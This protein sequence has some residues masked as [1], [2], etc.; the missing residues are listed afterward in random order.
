MRRYLPHS[1]LFSLALLLSPAYGEAVFRAE[2]DEALK[3]FWRGQ[4]LLASDHLHPLGPTPLKEAEGSRSD[5]ARG[6]QVLNQWKAG[7]PKK[8]ITWRREVA[9]NSKEVIGGMMYRIPAWFPLPQNANCLYQFKIPMEAIRGMQFS[10]GGMNNVLTRIKGEIGDK[11]PEGQVGGIGALRYLALQAP[12]KAGSPARNLFFDFNPSGPATFS[13]GGPTI[14]STGAWVERHGD[15]LLVSYGALGYQ[16]EPYF[17]TWMVQWRISEDAPDAY[18]RLHAEQ[19][20]AYFGH[21][22]TIFQWSFGQ[23]TL[24]KPKS[25]HDYTE[26]SKGAWAAL[27]EPFD[28]WKPAPVE[29]W[30]QP[31]GI[32]FSGDRARGVLH[33][34]AQGR[35]ENR[36]SFTV[37]QPGLYLLTLRVKADDRKI[38]PGSITCNGEPVTSDLTVEPGETKVITFSG[39]LERTEGTLQFSGDWAVSTL[40]IQ[41]LL[42]AKE[43]F[44]IRRGMWLVDEVPTPAAFYPW[45][46]DPL[47]IHT[48]TQTLPTLQPSKPFSEELVGE[49][50][51]AKP[52]APDP[53]HKVRFTGDIGGFGPINDGSFNEFETEETIN[54]RL[55]EVEAAGFK[56][57]LINGLLYRLSWPEQ[58]ERVKATLARIAKL[59]HQ[60]GMKVVDHFD[61]TVV[62]NHGTGYRVLLEMLDYTLRDVRNGQVT[63][64]FCINNPD[65]RKFFFGFLDGWI[66]ETN[67]DGLMLDEVAFHTRGFCGCVHCREKFHRDTGQVLP[68][69]E[70]A[71]ELLNQ[72]SPLW[73]LWLE[74]RNQCVGDWFADMREQTLKKKDDFFLMYYAAP[75]GFSTSIFTRRPGGTITYAARGAN[76]LGTETISRNVYAAWRSNLA[77]RAIFQSLRKAYNVPVFNLIYSNASPTLAYSGWIMNRMH[78]QPT[79]EMFRGLEAA[80]DR[81]RYGQWTGGF[82]IYGAQPVADIAVLFS[83]TSRDYGSGEKDFET[84]MLGLCEQLSD[85]HLPYEVVLEQELTLET[86]KPYR[87]VVLPAN[88]AMTEKTLSALEAYVTQGGRILSMGTAGSESPLGTRKARWLIGEWLGLT[89]TPRILRQP[90]HLDGPLAEPEVDRFA[91]AM[92]TVRRK[93]ELPETTEVL[94]TAGD[95]AEIAIAQGPV[96]KGSVTLVLPPLGMLKM[97]PEWK[98]RYVY[99]REEH[100]STLLKRLVHRLLEGRQPLIPVS[101]PE[102]VALT[103]FRQTAPDGLTHDYL[104]FY[105]ATGASFQQ[106]QRIPVNPPAAPF[107]PVAQEMAL[108]IRPSFDEPAMA[109]MRSPDWQG[110]RVLEVAPA[111]NGR[112]RVTIPAGALHAYAVIAIQPK[113]EP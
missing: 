62:P 93:G 64:G 91:L 74:W 59:A 106:G 14:P 31:E 77:H 84:K 103:H 38:G 79:W 41:S 89:T 13:N 87:L 5:E 100:D 57:L 54:R 45:K 15:H 85:W 18:P 2:A 72:R 69:D 36:L 71:P 21:L 9:W 112:V 55:D 99:Q 75:M 7:S 101:I 28:T 97:E 19:N 30:S 12:A 60:R 61:L 4:L 32:A 29:Q 83:E 26:P 96:G 33:S 1:T 46:E 107:P 109:V 43:D 17:G 88:E 22:P 53:R 52:Y 6:Y 50:R 23:G 34:R 98:P 10:A 67:I 25:P 39:Y 73:K 81:D 90:L 3:V 8:E 92:P 80:K 86:L 110:E 16:V 68:L 108:E 24:A 78:A 66:E 104:H 48:T 76:V 63:R 70:T 42:Y 65:F 40:A 35:G 11:L 51:H 44:V 95:D 56:T 37:P 113:R 94:A 111:K 47:K 105:N 49:M 58:H 102:K 20:A 27:K 82:D